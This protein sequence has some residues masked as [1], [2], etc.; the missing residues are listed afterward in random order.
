MAK[1][2][3][4]SIEFPES[5]TGEMESNLVERAIPILLSSQTMLGSLR[6][7]DSNR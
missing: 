2:I 7:F 3:A 4:G 1:H 6:L 5:G